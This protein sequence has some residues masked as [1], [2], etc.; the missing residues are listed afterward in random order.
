MKILYDHQVFS[1]QKYGGISRYF[2]EL[3]PRITNDYQAQVSLFMG[4]YI[5]EYGLEQYSDKFLD[6]D[7]QKYQPIP[8]TGRVLA[9]YNEFLF[10]RFAKK[11][12]YNIFHQTYYDNMFS[13]KNTKRVVTVYDMIHE[14]YP[15][16]FS[17]RDNTAKQKKECF[18]YADGIIC[19][20]QSTKR[21][22]L[23]RYN[24][25]EE[26]IAVSYL[27]NSLR[28]K[29]QSKSIIDSPYILY[30]GQRTG[31]KNFNLLL[32]AFAKS[33]HINENFKLVTF[34]GGRFDN[35]EIELMDSL[36]VT[37]KIE[38]YQGEDALLATLYKYASTFVY[39]SL[40]EGFGIPPLEAMYY[41]TPVIVSNSS[42]IPEVVEDAGLYFEPTSVE[43]L[44]E[45]L[46]CILSDLEL[47]NRLVE[48]G[49]QQ[50]KKFSWD[51]CAKETM[52]FYENICK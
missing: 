19:I 14:I 48:C 16:Y 50:E 26:K 8:K 38:H 7:G 43:D 13:R 27:G 18:R 11:N 24:I 23:E 36:R 41:G 17:S 31:Y 10:K 52:K 51:R 15:E 32:Q 49:Y 39:P 44:T 25:P 35:K 9:L 6:F 5:N 3:I 47:R 2:F 21:D 4:Y 34:G 40:Y 1:W 20:S 46:N 42:S 45:K 22:L 29:P 30:V 12:A 33:K 28:I 37:G